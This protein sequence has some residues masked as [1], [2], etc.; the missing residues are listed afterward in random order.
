MQ[1]RLQDPI[2]NFKELF[3][4]FESLATELA[5]IYDKLCK[6]ANEKAKF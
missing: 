1:L 5:E 4:D 3:H 6:E 2:I